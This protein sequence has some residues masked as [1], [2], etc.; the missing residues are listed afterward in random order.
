MNPELSLRPCSPCSPTPY[1]LLPTP[2]SLYSP[3]PLLPTPST[4]HSLLPTPYSPYSL[5]PLL[6]TPPTP[7]SPCSPLPTPFRSPT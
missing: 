5:L 7:Y 1:S 6:P 3:L 2:H 4:P